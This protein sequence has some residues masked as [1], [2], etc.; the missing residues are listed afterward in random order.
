MASQ[1]IG[2]FALLRF[3][4]FLP[5]RHYAATPRCTIC[6][7]HRLDKLGVGRRHETSAHL[8]YII[9]PKVLEDPARCRH[10]DHV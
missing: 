9:L 3:Y 10:S 4:H 7:P 8:D 6:S 5:R 1:Q 2:L